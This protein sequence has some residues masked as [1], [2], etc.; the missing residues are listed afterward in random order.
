MRRKDRNEQNRRKNDGKNTNS[1]KACKSKR[2]C[3]R[4]KTEIKYSEREKQKRTS[5]KRV[6]VD[7]KRRKVKRNKKKQEQ[8]ENAPP[9]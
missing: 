4:E 5:K 8:E 1:I 7:Y 9:K 3:Q 2:M 6:S